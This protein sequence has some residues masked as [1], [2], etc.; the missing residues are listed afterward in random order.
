MRRTFLP[1]LLTFTLLFSLAG[2]AQADPIKFA[3]YP[4]ICNGKIAF[5]YHGDIWVANDDGSQAYRLTAH[6]AMDQFPRFS[7]DGEWIAFTSNRMGNNDIWVMPTGGGVPRQVT[8]HTTGDNVLYWTPD[9]DR[10]VF[11]TSRGASG[12]GSPL[13]TVSVEGGL[14]VRMEMDRA[15]AGMIRQDGRLI[16]FNRLGFRYWRKGYR[17]NNNTD[18]WVQDLQTREI[19][20]LTDLEIRDYRE[21]AQDA[22]PMWGADGMIYF[23]SER[24]GIFNIWKIAATGGNPVQVT[25]HSADGVQYPSISPDGRTIIYENEFELWKLRSR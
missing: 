20:Q 2:T 8:F 21:H 25:S 18:I 6:V 5:S 17:G 13:H 4:H 9:G 15:A 14:P 19:T 10:I 12:W 23:M 16:A 3:R 1:L 22:Y 7:P 24:D 11:S